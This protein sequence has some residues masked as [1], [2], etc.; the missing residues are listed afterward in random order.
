MPSRTSHLVVIGGNDSSLPLVRPTNTTI[1]LIQ[2]PD[3]ATD[4]QRSSV[5]RFIEVLEISAESLT[6]LLRSIHQESPVT[7]LACLLESAILA[8][9]IAADTLNIPSNPVDAVR[10][11][12][13]KALTRQALDRHGVPQ[14][15]WRLCRSIDEVI[16]F[17]NGFGGRPHRGQ[18]RDGRR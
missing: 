5:D 10:T 17:R 7:A 3:R 4:F 1:T 13:N 18:A 15:P 14:Q 9:A 6:D 8:A 16:A 2:T 11:A 12:H